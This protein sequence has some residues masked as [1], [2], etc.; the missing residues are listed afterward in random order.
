M[1]VMKRHMSEKQNLALV[2]SLGN[3]QEKK[4]LATD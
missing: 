4:L 1:Q 2:F 3:E